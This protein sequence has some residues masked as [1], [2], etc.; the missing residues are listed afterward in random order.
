MNAINFSQ[1]LSST[2]T[3][4][5]LLT[6]VAFITSIMTPRFGRCIDR[7]RVLLSQM[8][9]IDI[10]SGEYQA[11]TKQLEILYKRIKL[12]RNSMVSAGFC[13]LFIVLTV[14]FNFLNLIVGLSDSFASIVFFL[15]ALVCLFFLALGFTFD[16][17]I[18]LNAIKLEI[19]ADGPDKAIKQKTLHYLKR[20]SVK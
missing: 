11:Q 17:I 14:G 2:I 13:I 7:I 4:V 1:I 10:E 6:G 16:F 20:Q 8:R 19:E 12:L 3:P 5:T 18:S 15:L 9:E